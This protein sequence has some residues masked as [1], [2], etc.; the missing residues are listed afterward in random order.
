MLVVT[1]VNRCRPC[2]AAH[3]MLARRAGL[4]AAEIE[5][6]IGG[7]VDAAPAGQRF[8]LRYAL[9]WAEAG[10]R[11]GEPARRELERRYGDY[12]ARGVEAALRVIWAGNL[13]GNRWDHLVR[14]R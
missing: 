11:I 1:R 7:R 10:G 9:Q 8:A 5:D 4:A 2:A 3:A 6:L 13:A 12:T 14:R